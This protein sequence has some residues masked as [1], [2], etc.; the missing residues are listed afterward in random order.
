MKIKVLLLLS[1]CFLCL[2]KLSA[3]SVVINKYFNSGGTTDIVELLVIADN[4]DMRGLWLKDFSGSNA[5]DAGGSFQFTTNT[6]W[7]SLRAGTLIV[8]RQGSTAASDV[9]VACNDFSLDIGLSNTTYFTAGGGSFDISTNDM[10]MIK[11]GTAAGTANN[12]H[13][14]RAGAAGT[15]W[16]NIS[17]GTKIGTTSTASSY[18]IV[19]NAS[20][21]IG[22]FNLGT[23]GVTVGTGYTLGSGN[24]T[25]NTNFI[26]FLRGPVASAA[27]SITGSGFSA[28]WSAVTGASS[29]RLDVSLASDFSSFVSGYSDLNVGNVTSYSVT[30]LSSTTTYYYR[31]RAVNAIPTTS[32]NSCVITATTGSG[33]AV[34]GTISANEYGNHTDGNNR[35]TS[36]SSVTYM[37]WDATNLYVGVT[38]ASLSEGF[39]MY[40]DKDPQTLVNGGTNANGTNI[41]Q[42][43]DNTNFAELQFRADLVLYVK[44]GY[45][46][47]RTANGSNGWSAATSGFGNYADTGTVREFSIPWSV[48]GG[49]PSAFNFFSYVTSSGGFVYAQLPSE[50]AGGNIGTAARYSRYYTVSSTTIGSGTPPFSRNSYVFNS[51]SDVTAFG[52]I[53]AYDFTM[54]TNGKYLSRTGSTA[55]NWVIGG[56]LSVGDGTIYL[57]SGGGPYG[58]T[59]VAGN[60]NVSG[61]SLNMDQT[62]GSVSVTGDLNVSGGSYDMAQT[63]GGVSITGNLNISG[64]NYTMNQATAATTVSGNVTVSSG[65]LALS[66][67][68]G[69]DVNVAGDWTIGASATQTNNGRAVTFNG[70]AGNQSITKTGGGIVYFDYLII[71]KS[72]GNA[73]VNATTDITINSSSGNVLQ[74]LNTGSLD[75]NGRSLT[76]NNAGGGIYVSGGARSIT[77]AAT[78]QV[79]IN[80]NKSVYYNNSGTDTLTFGNLLTV[81]VTNAAMDFGSG[82]TYIN[83]TLQLNAG[84]GVNSPP[85]YGAGSTLRYWYNGSNSVYGRYN[86]WNANGAGTIGTTKGYPNNVQISNTTILDLG[87]NGG[88]ATARALAGNLT[89]DDGAEMRMSGSSAMSQ[90]LTIGGDL[91]LGQGGSATMNLSGTSGGDLKV[92]GN[93]SFTGTYN[94]NANNRAVYFTKNGTQTITAPVARPST[95]NYIF[96]QP[97]TGSTT[98]QLVGADMTLAPT[99]TGSLLNFNSAADVFDLNGRTLTLGNAGIN[100]GISGLGTFKGSASSNLTLLGMGS[101]GTLRFTSG[102]QTLGTLTMSRQNGVVG[103][104]LGSDLAVNTALVLTNGLIDLA[105]FNLTLA[106]AATVT[107]GSSN[108]FAI[109]DGGGEFRKSYAATGSFTYPVGDNT[110]IAEYSPATLNFTAGSFTSAY[111]GV[112]VVDAKHPNNS[113]PTNYI[114]RYWAVSASGITSPT[115]NFSGQYIGSGSD[116]NGTETSCDSGR[117][118]GSAWILGSTLASNTVSVTGLTTLPA[119]NH[120]TGGNPLSPPEIDVLGNS[121]SIA[122]GDSTPSAADHTDFGSV[123]YGGT[124]VRTYTIKNTGASAL[125]LLGTPR[126]QLSGSSSFAVTTQPAAAAVAANGS[127]TFQITYTSGAYTAETASVSISNNDSDEGTYTFAVTGIGTPSVASDIIANSG[128][129]YNS[130]IAYKDYQA[131]AI[132]NTSNSIDLFK[133]DVRD[134]GASADADNLPTILSGITF[135]VSNTS[136]IRTAALFSGNALVNA[137]P[138]INTGAGTIAFSGLS[139]TNVTAADGSSAGLTLRVTFTSAVTDN[140]QFQVT[141]ASANVSASG[142]NTSSMFGSFASVVSSTTSNRN[143]IVVV[144]DRLAIVQQPSNTTVNAAMSP[145]VTVAGVDVNGNRDLDYTGTVSVTS[146]GTLSGT[147]VSAAAASG[148]ATFASLTHTVAGTGLILTASTTGLATGNSVDSSA[149]N[150]TAITSVAG[151]YR[152]NPAFSGIIYFNSTTA[153]GGVRPWQKYNGSSWV[154]VTGSS[155]TEG[156]EALVTKPGTIYITSGSGVSFAGGGTYNNIYIDMPTAT[157]VVTAASNSPGLTIAS[158]KTLEVKKGIFDCSGAFEML[159]SSSLIVRENAEMWI[160]GSSFLRSAASTFEVENNAYVEVSG[161]WTNHSTAGIWNGTEIFHEDSWFNI[162]KWTNSERLFDASTTVSTT[163]FAGASAMFGYLTIDI[164]SGALAGNWTVFPQNVSAYLTHRDFEIYN[165][166]TDNINLYSGNTSTLTIGGD[167]YAAGSGNIQGQVGNGALTLNVKGN[168]TKDGTGDF[169]FHVSST[170]TN[171]MTMNVDGNFTVNNGFFVMDANSTSGATTKINLKGNLKKLLSGRMTNSNSNSAN[172]S[173]NFLGSAAQTV[174]AVVNTSDMLRYKF[175]IKSGANVQI[176]NQDWKLADSSSITVESG[177][178]MD[179]GFSGTTALNVI[180]TTSSATT[181]FVLNSG[182]TLKITSPSGITAS[183]SGN[184]QTDT[185]TYTQALSTFHYIGKANQVTGDG[186]TTAS[187]SKSIICELNAD[188]LQ[189]SLTNSTSITSPGLLNLKKGQVIETSSSYIIGSTGGLTMESNTYYQVAALSSS[190]TDLIPRLDGLSGTYNLNGGTIE[191]NGAGSQILRGSRTYRNLTFSNTGTKTISSSVSTITGTVTVAND[192]VLDVASF[193]MGGSGTNLTMTHTSQYKNSGSGSKPDPSG[194]YSLS[195]TSKIEF[196]GTS[197]TLIRLGAPINYANIVVSGSNVSTSSAN[198]G[199]RMQSGTTFTVKNGAVFSMSNTNGFSGATSTA[200]DNTNSPT[201]TLETGSTIDYAGANQS[202]TPF[203][204]SY[205]NLKVSGT[206]TKTIPGTSEILVGNNLTV[207]ASTLQIDANKLLTVTNAINTIDNAIDVKNNGNLVQINDGISDTGKIYATRISRAM[208]ENDYVYWGTPVQE[209]AL[210]QLPS[211]F[212]TAYEWN[213]NGNYDGYWDGMAATTPGRGF[214]TRVS[215]AGQGAGQNFVFNGTPNNGVVTVP[216]DSYDGVTPSSGNSIL[217]GN[218]YPSAIYASSFITDPANLNKIGGTL[219]FWTSSTVYTGGEYNTN[220][221]ATWNLSGATGVKAST[222]FSSNDNLKPT[223]KIASGQGFFAVLLEDYNVTFNNGMRVRTTADNTQFFRNSNESQTVADEGKL[224]LNLSNDNHAF[225]QMLVAYVNGATNGYDNLFDGNSITS[226]EVNFY[227]LAD[228]KTLVIQGRA[229]P[230]T[231]SDLVPLGLR[232][233]NPGNYTITLDSTEGF[234]ANA[235]DIYVEDLQLGIIHDL[236]A[237]PYQFTT[238]AGTFDSRFVLRYTNGTLN[239]DTFESENVAVAVNKNLLSIKSVRENISAVAVFDIAGRKVFEKG[240][241]QTHEFSARDIVLNHQALIVKITLDNG[242]TVTKKIVY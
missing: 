16:T 137:S 48:I 223:G 216:G 148:L 2:G 238:D 98:L 196:Y 69:G 33:F 111:A 81:H 171:V 160:S 156:P 192:V 23:S 60:L 201:I 115:Y 194:T 173:F 45:R 199:I 166:E 77:S 20:S 208:V 181:A 200:I 58:T 56:N 159:G 197:A 152:T 8:L 59:A 42:G 231:D 154:D 102:S 32:G 163:T 84:G 29:Y 43:Y 12:I 107:G 145:S 193:N 239:T 119:T 127:L 63:S 74:L 182:G 92:G 52:P 209:N 170:S 103:A 85:V 106:S 202:L 76:L 95:F 204:P 228:Q 179:F 38:G 83:G 80:A 220:D 28:N 205:Y 30:G 132:T 185:R 130:N 172:I 72:T 88:A 90:P 66:T 213:L 158:G 4:T 128:Y 22:D 62:T 233:T 133:F 139:G 136:M 40:L 94:F 109:A 215:A 79:N 141:I 206:G 47:Y 41:G 86:E 175:F 3:Q 68:S 210:P 224:W 101:V 151:D 183:G 237:A 168:F 219:Y 34:D 112:K 15:Q 17:T 241:L 73:V 188:T 144:A 157:T 178:T 214:I 82:N 218:P 198:T 36:G 108:S 57:G 184:V 227:S 113:A 75:L 27:S 105:S 150:I 123:T 37:K 5:N 124:V 142:T 35:Q 234:F 235:Q 53:T 164:A 21:V 176:I 211:G 229:V 100:N 217:L 140:T 65:T 50:N 232:V 138:T 110:V 155:A 180:E 187:N 78:A 97:A 70:S 129:V 93:I 71:N 120:F 31:V 11:S 207:T 61:G 9:S 169:R 221:Y 117:W 134:G 195:T 236:N 122:N 96:F 46:E 51:A 121:V 131:A 24:N 230:F 104:V 242:T 87:A 191:L 91:I 126:V 64:G 222:D 99:S 6:L 10:V 212:D 67:V 26:T 54:N 116:I 135:S 165:E 147:P 162:T 149:F 55:G 89:I 146:T 118:D 226:N 189:L 153:S 174:D 143:R 240:D 25:N 161:T 7:S 190:G 177:A 186:I 114:S 13:T 225:R 14:L 19:D 18:A 125:N 49:M 1:L 203:S 39:V 167:L 44:N